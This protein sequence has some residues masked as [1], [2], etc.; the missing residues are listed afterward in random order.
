VPS[1]LGSISRGVFWNLAHQY[2]RSCPKDGRARAGQ[3]NYSERKQVEGK[4]PIV[5]KIAQQAIQDDIVFDLRLKDVVDFV[6][7]LGADSFPRIDTEVDFLQRPEGQKFFDRFKYELI[8]NV[9]RQRRLKRFNVHGQIEIGIY[10]KWNGIK[11]EIPL[12]KFLVAAATGQSSAD[13]LKAL[14]QL[15][16]DLGIAG[17]S[18]I[19]Q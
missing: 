15:M 4:A 5:I 10:G 19:S 12:R 9:V 3:L 14:E 6:R 11:K 13:G 8:A 17:R 16:V 2:K 18:D 7:G 1:N